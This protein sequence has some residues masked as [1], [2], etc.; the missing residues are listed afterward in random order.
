MSHVYIICHF[1]FDN[2]I[3]Y[4][5]LNFWNFYFIEAYFIYSVLIIVASQ[6][7]L[8][9]FHLVEVKNTHVVGYQIAPKVIFLRNI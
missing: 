7:Y 8:S 6:F 2:C 5:F 1:Y 3:A 9:D 4:S